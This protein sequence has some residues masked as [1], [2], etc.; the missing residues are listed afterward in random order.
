[1]TYEAK[2]FKAQHGIGRDFQI[3]PRTKSAIELKQ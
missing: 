1:M 2:K 3:R